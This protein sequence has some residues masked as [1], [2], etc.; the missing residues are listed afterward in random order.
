MGRGTHTQ[1][2]REE[3]TF[4]DR[5]RKFQMGRDKKGRWKGRVGRNVC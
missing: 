1:A 2:A 5:G 3:R 4:R